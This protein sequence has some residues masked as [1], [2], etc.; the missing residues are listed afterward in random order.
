MVGARK[1]TEHMEDKT[2]VAAGVVSSEVRSL[3]VVV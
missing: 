1:E 2:G 3:M